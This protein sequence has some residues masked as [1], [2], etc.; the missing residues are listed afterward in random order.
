MHKCTI[1]KV[2]MREFILLA[3]QTEVWKGTKK[4][5]C[6][7]WSTARNR[8]NGSTHTTILQKF[9]EAKYFRK[10]F[11]FKWVEFIEKTLSNHRLWKNSP[12]HSQVMN[13][14]ICN[15]NPSILPTPLL[16]FFKRI[17]NLPIAN[18]GVQNVYYYMYP[19]A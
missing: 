3:R 9:S 6:M 19:S 12:P 17:E 15:S 4:C 1:P 16:L 10:Q 8:Q 7:D 5:D 11:Y 14:C 18:I 2:E 13:I